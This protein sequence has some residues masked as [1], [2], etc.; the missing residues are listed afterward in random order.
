[1]WPLFLR[2][3]VHYL[4]GCQTLS[5]ENKNAVANTDN[6]K[7]VLEGAE[8]RSPGPAGGYSAENAACISSPL[9]R[10]K[11]VP[12]IVELFIEAPPVEKYNAIPEIIQGLGGCMT[13]RRDNPKGVLRRLAVESYRS[14]NNWHSKRSEASKVSFLF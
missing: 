10:E 4:L 12:V 6:T 1:M 11:L 14:D 9:I 8:I 3:L 7:H 5:H 2:K 13:T